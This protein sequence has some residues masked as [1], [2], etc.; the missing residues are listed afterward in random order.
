MP[1]KVFVDTNI[2]LYALVQSNDVPG[3]TRHQQ[4]R[5][6]LCQLIRPVINSQVIRG[7]PISSKAAEASVQRLL[8]GWYRD[9]EV[10]AS[11]VGQHL[12]ASSLR[13]N[14]R[15]SYW[16]SMIVAAALDAGCTTLYSED[17]QHGQR[18]EG[19]LTIVNPFKF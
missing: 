1:A 4:A 7:L 19:Q 18:V 13:T 11:N 16:D 9:S 17:M 15:F 5:E 2:W 8:Q 6:F 3:D 12:L 10:L 14:S